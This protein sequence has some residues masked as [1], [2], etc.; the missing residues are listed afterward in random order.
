MR[1]E[2][3]GENE[4]ENYFR[5]VRIKATICFCPFLFFTLF[6]ESRF[7]CER[8]LKYRNTRKLVLTDD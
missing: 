1:A 2:D 7:Y 6:S 3:E 8:I 5:N 4:N